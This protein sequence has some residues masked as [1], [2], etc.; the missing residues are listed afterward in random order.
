MSN[1][2]AYARTPAHILLIFDEL[3]LVERLTQRLE[4]AGYRVSWL[5]SWDTRSRLLEMLAAERVD[6]CLMELWLTSYAGEEALPAAPEKGY[7]ILDLLESYDV[8]ARIFTRHWKHVRTA[9]EW[10]AGYA[11]QADATQ[12]TLDQ[13]AYLAERFLNL[14]AE[15]V[16]LSRWLVNEEGRGLPHGHFSEAEGP[17]P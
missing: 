9:S 1:T 7:A 10:L 17:G 2:D 11:A 5:R 14:V 16:E 4:S 12:E 15:L 8:P 3:T 13:P 6:L